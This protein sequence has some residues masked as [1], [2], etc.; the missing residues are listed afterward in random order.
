MICGLIFAVAAELIKANA[1]LE[2][3]DVSSNII[4]LATITAFIIL[5]LYYYCLFYGGDCLQN[6]S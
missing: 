2:A 3:Q 6:M 4:F 5:Q 1:N